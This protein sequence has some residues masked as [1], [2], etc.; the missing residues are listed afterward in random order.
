[1]SD[2]RIPGIAERAPYYYGAVLSCRHYG[3]MR[4]FRKFSTFPELKGL[5]SKR[6]RILLLIK[7]L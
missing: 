1:M 7:K 2:G 3:L 4:V 6:V 5:Y